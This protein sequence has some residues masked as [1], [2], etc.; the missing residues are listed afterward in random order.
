MKNAL[1]SVLALVFSAAVLALALG[2]DQKP[3]SEAKNPAGCSCGKD[4]D[5][6]VCGVDKDCC[7]TG[8]KATKPAK[9]D[10][11]KDEKKPEKK[12]EKH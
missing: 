12:D 2:A 11:K 10:D 6:W 3:A 5:G 7:C 8:Q 9:K 1:R 4:A